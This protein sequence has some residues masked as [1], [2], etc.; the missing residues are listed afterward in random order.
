M[1]R[2]QMSKFIKPPLSKIEKER[3]AENFL[4]FAKE[5]DLE[6][7]QKEQENISET[8]IKEPTKRI[9]MRLPISLANDISDIAA[10]TGIAV[11]SVCIELLRAGAKPK[12]QELKK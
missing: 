8:I 10:L 6:N 9:T 1:E 12:L 4:N 11:N 5:R 2:S 3:K 7:L